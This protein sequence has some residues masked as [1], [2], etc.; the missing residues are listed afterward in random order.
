MLDDAHHDFKLKQNKVI[1]RFQMDWECCY[2]LQVA[3]FCINTVT[4]ARL[5]Y[6]LATESSTSQPRH[7][8]KNYLRCFG[9]I[10]SQDPCH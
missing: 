9:K 4:R 5:G 1:S 7:C 8:T 10:R 6:G 2:M 3:I